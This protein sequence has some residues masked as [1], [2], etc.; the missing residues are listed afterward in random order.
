MDLFSLIV[1]SCALFPFVF[2]SYIGFNEW[3]SLIPLMIT[4]FLSFII[5]LRLIPIIK[6]TT[7]AAGLYGKDL[8][9]NNPKEM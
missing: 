4:S 6:K 9:K 8:N 3:E 5:S 2:S 1:S 7:R